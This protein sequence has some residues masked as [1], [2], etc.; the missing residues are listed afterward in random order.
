MSGAFVNVNGRLTDAAHAMVPVFDHGFLFG[1]GVYEVCRTYHGEPFLFDRHMRRMRAS[2]AMIALDVPCG[3]GEFLRRA[4]EAMDAAGLG[5]QPDGTWREAYVRLILTRGVGELTY[6]PAATPEPTVVVIAKPH[7]APPDQHYTRGVP[8]VIV[9]VLRNHP[10]SVSPLIKSNN[11][12]NNALGMQQALRRGGIEAVFRNYRGEIAE[13]AQSNLFIV[14][15]G[16]VRTP[17]LDAGLLAGIT[18]AFV[19]EIAAELGCRAEE[20]VLH[21]RDLLGADEAFLTSTTKEIVPIVRVDE[22]DI[23]GGLPGPITLALLTEYRR[24]A[25]QM[26]AGACA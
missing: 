12:L 8:V 13:C 23:G 18:R 14:S 1:E 4:R 22:R 16:V 7:S 17:G 6:D 2:A 3:D 26:T 21:D 5:A 19:L 10:Q 25:H 24:R 9:D 11:L 20:A 15:G